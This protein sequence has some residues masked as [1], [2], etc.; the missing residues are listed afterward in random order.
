MTAVPALIHDTPFNVLPTAT[1]LSEQHGQLSQQQGGSSQQTS[2]PLVVPG[3]LSNS[4][5]KKLAAA[6]AA[7][8]RAR[9]RNG[10]RNR[11]GRATWMPMA[12]IPDQ[13]SYRARAPSPPSLPPPSLPGVTIDSWRA[14]VQEAN[15]REARLPTPPPS[16]FGE[17]FERLMLRS[18]S[19]RDQA[20]GKRLSAT[21]AY[22]ATCDE[23]ASMSRRA[24]ENGIGQGQLASL[25]R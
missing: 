20:T 15:V 11:R 8:A 12:P 13:S 14:D 17:I 16:Y 7:K 23:L 9:I 1:S 25:I 4:T 19:M 5:K 22:A 21:E 18:R 3:K 24:F 10:G 6:E 2:G